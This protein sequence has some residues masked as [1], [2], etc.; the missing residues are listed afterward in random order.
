VSVS[1]EPDAL[2]VR[3]DDNGGGLAAGWDQPGHYGVR[4]MRERAAALGG[5]FELGAGE[6]GGTQVLARLPLA[7]HA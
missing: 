5:T 4:G 3:V 2:V 6:A 1:A 7:A